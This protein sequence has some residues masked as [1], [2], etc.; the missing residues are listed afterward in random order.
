M[1]LTTWHEA[2]EIFEVFH[3][4]IPKITERAKI[5]DERFYQDLDRR[6]GVPPYENV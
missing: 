3:F 4:F 5:A 2:P 6:G 1:P